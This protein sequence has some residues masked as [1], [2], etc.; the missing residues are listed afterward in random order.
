M[1]K[2]SVFKEKQRNLSNLWPDIPDQNTNYAAD[3]ATVFGAMP[4]APPTNA[5]FHLD[6]T[7]QLYAGK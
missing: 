4:S 6:S 5:R 3:S 1:I 7:A 2:V